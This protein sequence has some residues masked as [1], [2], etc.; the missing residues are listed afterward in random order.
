MKERKEKP[1]KKE[2]NPL[3]KNVPK[4]VASA[5][6]DEEEWLEKVQQMTKDQMDQEVI[7]CNESLVDYQ[8]DMAEDPDLNDLK[9]RLKEGSL[10]Y[11]DGIRINS[12]R[13]AYLVYLKRSL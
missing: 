5:L 8:K 4:K 1:Q 2:K 11:R 13:T 6:K 7:K 10:V 12:A 9:D 3:L